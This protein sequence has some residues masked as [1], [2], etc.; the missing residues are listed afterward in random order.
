M[1][2]KNPPQDFTGLWVYEC[3]TGMIYETEYISGVENGIYRH[4][5]KS[6]VVLREGQKVDGLDHGT[7]TLRNNDG[8]VLVKYE[9]EYGTGTHFIY[10]SSGSIGWE[11]PYK[12]GLIHGIKRHYISGKVVSEEKYY[13]G[14]KI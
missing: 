7:I 1:S 5:L 9:F 3:P 11:I 14:K 13:E 2:N 12:S 8:N 4:K 10:T 6:G